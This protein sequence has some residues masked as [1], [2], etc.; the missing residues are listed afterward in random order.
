MR[1]LV[2]SSLTYPGQ[3]ERIQGAFA[4]G[5]ARLGIRV[6]RTKPRHAWTNGFVERLQKTILHE[7][8]RIAFRR[9]YFTA[10]GLCKARSTGFC[11]STTTSGRIVVI[12]SVAGRPPRCS[13][14]RSR[15]ERVDGSVNTFT[16][17]DKLVCRAEVSSRQPTA[18]IAH[19]T[20]GELPGPTRAACWSA[21]AS[22]IKC[23]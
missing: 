4:A 22:V 5:C 21:G 13:A 3:R 23:W 19:G 17:L 7:H 16:K 15:H 10:V 2:L 11:S 1:A 20:P 12:V 8:W 6:T 9:Q 14:A 18:N